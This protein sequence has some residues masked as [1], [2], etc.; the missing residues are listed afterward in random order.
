MSSLRA[1][2]YIPTPPLFEVN[3]P[4]LLQG[5]RCYTDATIAPDQGN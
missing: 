5:A 1:G 4:T 3:F 2:I